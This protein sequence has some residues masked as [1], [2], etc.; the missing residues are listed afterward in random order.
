MLYLKKMFN[1]YLFSWTII[2]F[3]THETME[4]CLDQKALI[5]IR[6]YNERLWAEC[7]YINEEANNSNPN[8]AVSTGA[9]VYFTDPPS[10]QQ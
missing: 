5:E 10:L 9:N 4:G 6:E 7:I 3:S 2:L 8:T 1:L